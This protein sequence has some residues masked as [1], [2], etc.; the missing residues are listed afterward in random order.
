VIPNEAV[1]HAVPDGIDVHEGVVCHTSAQPADVRRQ[2]VCQERPQSLAL[3]TLDSVRRALMR[4]A[5]DALVSR[6]LHSAR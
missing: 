6:E 2:R 5:V 4:G 3:G 1:R